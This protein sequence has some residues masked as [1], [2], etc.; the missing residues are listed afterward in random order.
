MFPFD[1]AEMT[2]YELY[3]DGTLIYSDALADPGPDMPPEVHNTR[4][5][6]AERAW[7]A[8]QALCAGN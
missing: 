1:L 6:N 8:T 4:P 3:E 7:Q 2:G 5:F